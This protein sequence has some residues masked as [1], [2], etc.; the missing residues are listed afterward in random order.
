[1]K[2]LC[3]H[4]FAR[5]PLCQIEMFKAN[6]RYYLKGGGK[7][8]DVR[9][10]TCTPST[11]WDVK[12]ASRISARGRWG[13]L[14][15]TWSRRS[16]GER[17]EK[18]LLRGASHQNVTASSGSM[19]LTVD[20]IRWDITTAPLLVELQ[21]FWFLERLWLSTNDV[22]SGVISPPKWPSAIDFRWWLWQVQPCFSSKGK[23]K[24]KTKDEC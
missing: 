20:L 14:P 16:F 6:A 2:Y 23:K 4:P 8:C 18:Q 15:Q 17:S 24:R 5:L 22:R 21:V 1:M 12:R 13:E 10:S 11:K 9:H 3:Y 7:P 19:W